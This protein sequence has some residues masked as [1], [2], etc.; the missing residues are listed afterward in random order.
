MTRL[1]VCAPLAVEAWAVRRGLASASPDV[2][3]VRA[4]MRLGRMGD[5][6]S[7]LAAYDAVAVAGLGGAFDPSL[8]PGAVLVATEV[9]TG[10]RRLPCA[11]A[12]LLAGE[13]ASEGLDVTTG[14]LLTTAR[15]VWN[16]ARAPSG[17]ARAVDLEAGP[18]MAAAAGRPAAAV[19][20]IVDTP[21]RPLLSPA[22]L[23]G[24]PA[25]LRA[26]R[27]VGPALV[28]WSE[29]IEPQARSSEG[30]GT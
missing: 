8:R 18:L 29:A 28:R 21:D 10:G 4:G 6:A 5:V 14:P 2:T 13:L 11:G 19:R 17:D 12:D 3:V 24:G 27:R 23:T 25:A 1:V 15:I 16:L 20:V 22:T 26:L 9:L 7:E 30:G